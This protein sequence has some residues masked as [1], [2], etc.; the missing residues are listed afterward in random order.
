M[1]DNNN[2]R[3][4]MKNGLIM[5]IP[6]VMVAQVTM[7]SIQINNRYSRLNIDPNNY[8]REV[9]KL[10]SQIKVNGGG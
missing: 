5:K 8:K 7:P 10:L 1:T 9:R 3:I 6:K 2:I 4:K